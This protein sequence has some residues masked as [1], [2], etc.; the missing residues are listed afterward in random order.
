[1]TSDAARLFLAFARF[2]LARVEPA[3][4]G[5]EVR[6]R[7]LR[8]ES[9]AGNSS[10]IAAVIAVNADGEIISSELEFAKPASR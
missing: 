2:P 7:D 8:L 3:A 9:T 6:I 1:M 5:W 10:T 4:E